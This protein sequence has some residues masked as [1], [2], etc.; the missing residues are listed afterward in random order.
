MQKVL[1][2]TFALMLFFG[3]SLAVALH[4]AAHGQTVEPAAAELLLGSAAI[5]EAVQNSVPFNEAIVFS[6]SRKK[7]YCYTDF[8]A[9]PEK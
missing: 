1:K 4:H 5:C 9:V 3:V 6:I 2:I 7:L 8:V